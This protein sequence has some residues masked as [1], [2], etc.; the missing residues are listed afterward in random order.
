VNYTFGKVLG[1]RDGDS[2]NGAQAGPMVDPFSVKANYGT[3]T[4]DHRHIFN[5]AYVVNLPSPIR[6]N[7]FLAGAVNGWQFS[8]VTQIQSGS[9]IQPNSPN[10]DLNVQ[11]GNVFQNGGYYGISPQSWIGSNASGATIEPILTCDP[12]SGLKSGQRFNP[13]CFAPPPQGSMGDIVWPN[14]TGPAFLE[15][16]LA[17]FKNFKIREHQNVQFRFSAFNFINHPNS[18]FGL[19]GNNDLTLSF[20]NYGNSNHTLSSSNLSSTT[21]G[22]PAYTQGNRLIEFA[23]KYY[24]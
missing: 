20:I 23:L 15:T 3:L 2:Q 11:W 17:L 4:Y 16:D 19:N 12:R 6:G 5:A 1:I 22:F 24:F 8:G 13:S 18:A 7:A 14:I 21:N 10:G 9:P